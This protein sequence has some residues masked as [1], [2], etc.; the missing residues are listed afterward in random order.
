LAERVA[1]AAVVVRLDPPGLLYLV[2]DDT[3][4]H[5]P[6]KH[7]YG[8]GG[9]AIR[10]VDSSTSICSPPLCTPSWAG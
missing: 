10:K 8:L 3:P 7:V 5:K 9:F 2:V 1:V 4:L 6:G